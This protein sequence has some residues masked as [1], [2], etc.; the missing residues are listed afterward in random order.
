MSNKDALVLVLPYYDEKII[1]MI[2][3]KYNLTSME[4]IRKFINSKTYAMLSNEKLEMLDFSPY[5]IFDM[6]IAEINTGDP[7][8]SLY[9]RR[10]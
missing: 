1:S 3:D 9:I 7:R 10:D 4:A 5:G 6:Y 8:N 2:K